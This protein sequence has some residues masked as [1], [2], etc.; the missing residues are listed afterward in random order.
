MR[1]GAHTA[2][3]DA[4]RWG[5]LLLAGLLFAPALGAQA[6]HK[7]SRHGFQFKPPKDFVAIS[8]P[9]GNPFLVANYQDPSTEYGSGEFSS[10]G[11]NRT[12]EVNLIPG[13]LESAGATPSDEQLDELI[14][15]IVD[16]FFGAATVVKPRALT[17]DRIRGREFTLVDETSPVTTYVAFLPQEEG[18]F[19]FEGTAIANRFDKAVG[20]FS[21]SAKSFRRIEKEDA[22]ERKAEMDQ[23]SSQDRWLKTQIDKLPPGWSH[24]RTERYLFLF[25]TDK[26]FIKQMA[27]QVEALRDVY[28]EMYPPDRPIEAVSVVRVFKDRDRYQAYGGPPGAGGHWDSRQRELVFFDM[29]PRS[30][31]LCVLNHEAFHQYIYYFYGEL[32]PH[33]WYNEG[34]GDY[35]SGAK[36][37][38]TYRVTGFGAAPGGFDRRSM[39]KDMVR[40]ARQGKSV[41]DGAAAPLSKLLNFSQQEF[42]DNG[43]GLRPVAYYP[44]GWAVVHMLRE[45]KSLDP[46]VARILPDYLENLLAAREELAQAAIQRARDDAEAANPGSS[47]GMT[48][49]PK[50]W[51]GRLDEDKIQK[52]AYQ[53]TFKDWTEEDWQRFDE[54]FWDYA[55]R[56]L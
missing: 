24:L 42:Y 30:E 43:G 19:V 51:Y 10:S 11:F 27:D 18:V 26:T 31:T 44:Q 21:K 45:S 46:K 48:F 39:L 9:P 50:E 32:A 25:D 12:F 7:D 33:S 1:N 6:V 15:E 8:L 53:K 56:H 28:E 20:E 16:T 36:L 2:C 22:D 40:L 55:E 14:V 34:H 5:A 13:M 47:E 17:V 37:T 3:R 41:A 52:L 4:G 23:L 38:K 29:S 54:A 49:D 35:F